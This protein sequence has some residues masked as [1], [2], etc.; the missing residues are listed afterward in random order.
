VGKIGNSNNDLDL[1]SHG[2]GRRIRVWEPTAGM[3]VDEVDNLQGLLCDARRT[4]CDNGAI[5]TRLR[6]WVF[7]KEVRV[8]IMGD[9][10]RWTE[11]A[12]LRER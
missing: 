5:A 10:A 8:T 4:L 12:D 6:L 7:G 9:T 1:I 11:I 2:V 3:Q